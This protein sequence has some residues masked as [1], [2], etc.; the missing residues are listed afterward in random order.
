MRMATTQMPKVERLT[1]T[2]GAEVLDVDVDRLLHDEALQQAVMAALEESGVLAFRE[3]NIDD[4]SQVAFCRK[5]G[6]VRRWEGQQIPE[7]SVISLTPEN[8]MAE[9][10]RGTVEWHI[11]GTLDQD[12]PMKAGMLSAKIVSAKGGETEFAS[13]YAAYD[14][15]SDEEKERFANVRVCHSFEATQ[16]SSYPNPTPEQLADWKQKGGRERPLV[17]THRSGRKSLVLSSSMDYVVGMAV[18]EGRALLAELLERATR[19]E[20]VYSHSWSV[21]DTILWD[22]AGLL[23]RVQPYDPGSRREL[24]RTSLVGTEPIQ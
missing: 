5:L 16:R 12:V 9:Y 14:D 22:N 7:I 2:V 18:D 11:D 6:E 19:P 8:P 21:G 20:R 15:F 1:P 4:E 10:L 24:H 23:H 3:L 17:W 13:A